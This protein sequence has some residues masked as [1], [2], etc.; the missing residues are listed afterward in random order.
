MKLA[1]ELDGERF[2]PGESVTGRVTAVE[3]DD[4]TRRLTIAVTFAERTRDFAVPSSTEHLLHEGP[5]RTGQIVDF[6]FD[7][8]RDALPSVK[9][10][11]AELYWELDV[12]SDEPGLD[13]HATRRLVVDP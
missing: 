2:R 6:S 1:L 8:P 9:S 5:L 7:L 10:E 13:T 11:H 4:E 3:G 12:A